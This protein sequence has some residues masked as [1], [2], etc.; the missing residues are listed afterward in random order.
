MY[1]NI[2]AGI[3]RDKNIF[4]GDTISLCTSAAVGLTIPDILIQI[5][6]TLRYKKIN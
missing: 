5:M 2:T 3:N 6:D 1:H 4:I